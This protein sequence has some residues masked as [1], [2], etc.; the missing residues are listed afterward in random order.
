MW[1]L[2][3]PA[4][5]I[6]FFR[7]IIQE[8]PDDTH[9]VIVEHKDKAIGGI[10]LLFF[11]DTAISGWSGSHSEYFKFYP[12]NIAY[13]EAIKKCCENGY[14]SFDFGRSMPNSGIHEFKKSFGAETKY[15]QY[16]FY[17]NTRD[18][19]PDVTMSNPKRQL[20]AKVWKNMPSLIA[21][22][23]GPKLRR[24]FP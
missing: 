7:N 3:S 1:H 8:F 16:L 17:L 21:N 18:K 24:N 4:H 5:D 13:W 12:N 15:L 14:K 10:F 11:K 9:I 19:V 23:V 20:F 2:G 6:I 22:L